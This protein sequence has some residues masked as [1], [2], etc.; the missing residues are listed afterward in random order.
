MIRNLCVLYSPPPWIA[1]SVC[2]RR[3]W[4]PPL[5][6]IN[7]TRALSRFDHR[8]AQNSSYSNRRSQRKSEDGEVVLAA[9]GPARG[10]AI[11]TGPVM[12]ALRCHWRKMPEGRLGSSPPPPACSSASFFF[13]LYFILFYFDFAPFLG[14]SVLLSL[15]MHA[16]YVAVSW[17]RGL[18][19][20]DPRLESL[21]IV[22]AI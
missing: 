16:F 7:S 14:S 11:A 4:I 8:E 6:F 21:L 18:Q 9:I 10:L 2:L 15:R 19:R 17:E 12:S 5:G 3:F 13:P 1:S 22:I 20:P